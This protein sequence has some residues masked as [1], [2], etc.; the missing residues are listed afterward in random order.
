MGSLDVSSRQ[1]SLLQ[2]FRQENVVIRCIT[3]DGFKQ[4][5]PVGGLFFSARWDTMRVEAGIGAG[6][7]FEACGK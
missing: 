2:G 3:G 6:Y 7:H 4:D 5:R 1:W